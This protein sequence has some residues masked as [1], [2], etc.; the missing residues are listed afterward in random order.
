VSFEASLQTGAG[1]I[2]A[3]APR[4][5][6]IAEAVGAPVFMRPAWARTWLEH[7]APGGEAWLLAVGDPP[8][9]IW[10]L[11]LQRRGAFKLLRSLGHGV[12][13]YLGPL[14]IAPSVELIEAFGRRIRAESGRYDLLDVGSLHLSDDLRGCLRAALG[15]RACERAYERC[16]LISTEG[17][18]EDYL[19]TRTR[20][21]REN[22]KRSERRASASAPPV[23]QIEPFTR[24]LFEELLGVERESWKWQAGTAY[25]QEAGRCAFLKA[26]LA[27]REIGSEIW[28]CRIG[29]E[30]AAFS[31]VF[32]APGLRHYYLPSFCSRYSDVGTFL[33]RELVQRSFG[34][35]IRE[36][37]LLQGD[38]GYKLAWATGERVVH[39]LASAGRL[40]LGPVALWAKR[41]RWK[42]AESPRVHS[43]RNR[44]MRR[45][46]DSRQ[47]G[48]RDQSHADER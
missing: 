5:L 47:L 30:L 24:P 28:T 2:E 34:T 1:A 9:A 11:V 37:D 16:P 13:D 39:Q 17:S 3:L 21:F 14:A 32:L 26:A 31:V 27:E 25:L 23:V 36:V 12:S 35:G 8:V 44:W 15:T 29:S 7:L 48:D 45:R 10:P 43:L 42:L 6:E 33:L 40:P 20:K 19:R 18:W 4:W 46:R 22:L 38:E 41:A